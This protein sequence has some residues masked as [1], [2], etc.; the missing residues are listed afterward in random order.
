MYIIHIFLNLIFDL[1]E[2]IPTLGLTSPIL[3]HN[4]NNGPPPVLQLINPVQ[5]TSMAPN[6]VTV[7]QSA[8]NNDG[9]T[10]LIPQL[11]QSDSSQVILNSASNVSSLGGPTILPHVRAGTAFS[12]FPIQ[13]SYT[14]QA[15]PFR[16]TPI[17]QLIKSKSS[18]VRRKKENRNN[19][20]PLTVAA[21]LRE[22]E[23]IGK[24]KKKEEEEKK[25]LE[26]NNCEVK[27]F[28]K[29]DVC[30]QSNFEKE[31]CQLSSIR[32][33][34]V[35]SDLP[36]ELE[37]PVKECEPQSLNTSNQCLQ[38]NESKL[39]KADKASLTTCDSFKEDANKKEADTSE[40]KNDTDKPCQDDSSK[41]DVTKSEDNPV[42]NSSTKQSMNKLRPVVKVQNNVHER[43]MKRLERLRKE[44]LC[45]ENSFDNASPESPPLS[46]QL[47]QFE[48]G[49]LVWGQMRGNPSWPGKLITENDVPGNPVKSDKGKV[50][51]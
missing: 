24:R 1:I 25:K 5:L 23:E 22:V 28:N 17:N 46:P 33:V 14:F 35:Q 47:R 4:S 21:I 49:D 20:Q 8:Q 39:S 36:S 13:P 16:S 48:I 6:A 31:T 9:T 50:S 15:T 26:S 40:H 44:L 11:V 29:V 37:N 2:V 32:E 3:N 38:S 18:K 30:S 51:I 27:E 45:Y 42:N 19:R 10:I 7:L 12:A 41:K 34:A 43:N